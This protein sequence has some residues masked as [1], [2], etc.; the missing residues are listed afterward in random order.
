MKSQEKSHP[1]FS[2]LLFTEIER[3][4]EA[5]RGII[6]ILFFMVVSE[7]KRSEGRWRLV[8]AES[9]PGLPPDDLE[10]AHAAGAGGLPAQG[11]D[12]PVV[13]ADLVAGV[14]AGR[15]HLLLDVEGHLAAADAQGVRLVVALSKRARSLRLE[16]KNGGKRGIRTEGY[17]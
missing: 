13:L 6:I 15:A 5:S 8:S 14:A 4:K 1:S 2:H 10:V 11:L 9:V 7:K 17:K 3:A 16:G 12:G